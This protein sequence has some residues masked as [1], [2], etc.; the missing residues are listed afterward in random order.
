[1]NFY[2]HILRRGEIAL[3]DDSVAIALQPMNVPAIVAANPLDF[4]TNYRLLG[5][6]VHIELPQPVC[7]LMEHTV[8]PP[9]WRALTKTGFDCPAWFSCTLQNISLLGHNIFL[10]DQ[11]CFNDKLTEDRRSWLW[12]AAHNDLSDVEGVL[13]S[14]RAAKVVQTFPGRSI[15]IDSTSSN[16]YHHWLID[17]IPILGTLRAT[18]ET[19]DRFV[20][21]ERVSAKFLKIAEFYGMALGKVETFAARSNGVVEF[22]ELVFASPLNLLNEWIRPELV[23]FLRGAIP[24]ASALSLVKPASRVYLS[25][26]DAPPGMRTLLNEAVLVAL[27]ESRGFKIIKMG[28]HDFADQVSIISSADIIVGLHGAALANIVFVR[29]GAK[30]CLLE[31][32]YKGY[33]FYRQLCA[34]L[35]VSYSV[36][37]GDTFANPGHPI[38]P[39]NRDWIIDVDKVSAAVDVLLHD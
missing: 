9:A 7:A 1:M 18:Q 37:I 8:A 30:F 39:Q 34:L 17:C 5:E 31:Q 36:V 15:L 2:R 20:V 29:Q 25:R 4:G 14:R 23:E 24:R 35:Q 10:K 12:P 38:A 16:N 32:E 13:T 19:V 27:L 33:G 26:L 21:S 6:P 11:K 22:E 3:P 28:E